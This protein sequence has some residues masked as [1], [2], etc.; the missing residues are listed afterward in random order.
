MAR[1]Q[2]QAILLAAWNDGKHRDWGTPLPEST[3]LAHDDPTA[4]YVEAMVPLSWVRPNEVVDRYDGTVDMDRARRYADSTIVAPVHLL[5]GP[6]MQK[7]GATHANVSDG[8]HRVTAARMRGDTHILALM[9]LSHMQALLRA[10]ESMRPT[11]HPDQKADRGLEAADQSEGKNTMQ[12]IIW[13][14]GRAYGPKG[15][16][17]AAVILPGQTSIAFAD[18]DRNIFAV[19]QCE[20]D[21]LMD[22]RDITSTARFIVMRE[23]DHGRYTDQGLYEACVH[24][25]MDAER[26]RRALA[27]CATIGAVN[28]SAP[29]KSAGANRGAY[30]FNDRLEGIFADHYH[31]KFGVPVGDIFAS[32]LRAKIY[33]VMGLEGDV[34]TRTANIVKSL[35]SDALE[36]LSCMLDHRIPSVEDEQARQEALDWLRDNAA[37]K[38]AALSLDANG[39][40]PMVL[41]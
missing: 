35:S 10:R 7:R 16:R 39:D 29:P 40:G 19:V 5:F 30:F 2:A 25:H 28:E 17:M 23:Y 26:F 15:Q 6:R 8:G 4:H 38:W 32:N 33:G 31:D 13:N 18:A 22:G 36:Q 20:K 27:G 24:F 14:T 34:K 9:P 37:E 11:E 1:D 41:G 21:E 12:S 3:P